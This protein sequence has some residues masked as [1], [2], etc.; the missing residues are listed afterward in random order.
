MRIKKF[1]RVAAKVIA[2]LIT[3]ILLL[4]G[5]AYFYISKNKT[6]L[7]AQVNVALSEK[8]KGK[9]SLRD[10]DISLWNSFPRI[11]VEIKD[12]LVT[13]SLFPV[14][15]HAFLE[16][17]SLF[18]NL[19]IVKLIRKKPALT[20]VEVKDGSVSIYTDTSGYSNDY[21]VRG[22]G[23]KDSASAESSENISIKR[24]QLTNMKVVKI[25]EKREKLFTFAIRNAVIKIDDGEQNVN[26]ETDLDMTVGD[27]AFYTKR[28]SFLKDALFDGKFTIFFNKKTEILSFEKINVEL[29]KHFY[30][31]TGKFDLGEKNPQFT[32]FVN[33]E[34][35]KYEEVKK[36][37][38]ARIARSLSMV[39]V[40]KPID[41]NATIKGPLR[42]GDPYVDVHWKVKDAEMKT[43]FMDFEHA[44]FT[45]SFNN[46]VQKG[47]P[48]KDPNSMISVKDFTAEW[49]GLP[50]HSGSILIN[51]L[52]EP[53]LTCDLQSNFELSKMNELI[54]SSALQLQQGKGEVSLKYSGPVVR[55]AN[56]L[57]LINGT[58][59]V[60]NGT[61]LYEPRNVTMTGVNG[62]LSFRNS[63]L[64][65][66]KLDCK[67]LGNII[68]MSGTAK[69]IMTL[70]NTA[71]NSVTIDYSIYSPNLDLNPF[72]FLFSDRKKAPASSNIGNKSGFQG[73][74]GK[75]DQI[76]E[77]SKIEVSLNAAKTRFKSFDA[78]NLKS[79]ITIL[80]NSYILNNVSMN[81]AGGAMKMNGKIEGTNGGRHAAKLLADLNDVSVKKLFTSFDNFG[82]DAIS[83][84]NLEGKLTAK[85]NV[86]LSLDNKGKVMPQTANGFVDFSLKK[87][88]LHDYEPLK[89][90][91][92]FVF[93]R[94]DFNDIEFAEIKNNFAIRK[95]EITI[96][97]M[98]I[99][100]SV[101]TLFFE[102]LYS[103]A[104]NTDVS[105]QVPLSNLKKRD[106]DYEPQNIGTDKKGGRS[107]FLRGQTGKDGNVDFKLDV[108]K[109]YFKDHGL[110]N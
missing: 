10:A 91:Q 74:A 85:A 66:D 4:F 6:K 7:I 58:V 101:L 77:K 84:K 13:D 21:L 38:P 69:K 70:I 33:T 67:V 102:G 60:K 50:V 92:K 40:N 108:F 100:S 87:G 45:G 98:E 2:I 26:L 61:M 27:L 68:Q 47:I 1:L 53:L 48:R 96:P 95:G 16:A 75:L 106:E 36:I 81:T 52:N 5:V 42:G 56:S 12:I 39:S 28:G 22:N 80:Q 15:K 37:L 32:L 8:L 51:D 65:I 99:Q 25:D 46:E 9:I 34:K 54:G 55:D 105:V 31:L 73:F 18:V 79:Q 3:I 86:Q 20:G 63:D 44:S 19:N 43:I 88:V 41:A 24:V 71:P 110:Q 78:D 89:K 64:T 82:Q 11:S 94:R 29:N 104:G 59:K 103:P 49:Y 57:A 72:I 23:Q 62:N 93:K 90:I 14:H 30:V 109:K 97:R 17:K 83:A 76:L 107:I 35:A